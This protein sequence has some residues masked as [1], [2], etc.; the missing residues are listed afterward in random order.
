M[1]RM[2]RWF[3]LAAMAM[4]LVAGGAMRS[5]AGLVASLTGGTTFGNFARN[6]IT[7]GWSF[8]TTQAISV[9]ALAAYNPDFEVRLY[10]AGGTV[11]ATASPGSADPTV[12]AGDLSFHVKTIAPVTL[13]ANTTYYI[14]EDLPES[15]I[16]RTAESGSVTTSPLITFGDAVFQFGTGGKPTSDGFSGGGVLRGVFG[17]NFEASAVSAV[18]EPATM[19]SGAVA[20]LGLIGFGRRRRKAKASA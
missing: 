18:P 14:A 11:L 13:A 17:P 6:G 2:I 9:T 8:T 1:T 20:G 5:E 16:P 19:V 4:G 3:G 10:D 12:V 7:A 15:V